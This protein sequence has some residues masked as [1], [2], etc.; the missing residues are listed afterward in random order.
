MSNQE[1]KPSFSPNQQTQ[2]TTYPNGTQ[3]LYMFNENKEL[4]TLNTAEQTYHYQRDA[5]GRITSINSVQGTQLNDTSYSYDALGRLIQATSTPST[6]SGTDVVTEQS[7]STVTEFTY[8]KAGNNLHKQSTYDTRMNQLLEDAQYRY[9]Y[10][11]NGN[12]NRKI[13]KKTNH[14]HFYRYNDLNQLIEHYKA[15][16]TDHYV[17]RLLY[18]YDGFNRRVTKTYIDSKDKTKSYAHHYLYDD[19]NI[20][21]IL[22]KNNNK[23]LLAT[24][25][26]HPTQIDTPLSITNH[27]T[28]KTYYYHRDHQGSIVALTNEEGKVVE[29]ITYDGHYGVILQHFKQETTL[30]P[31]GYTGRETDTK[32]LY[33]YRARYYDPTTQRFLSRDPIEFEAGDFNFYRYVGN[34][35]VNF[36]DPTGLA[37]IGYRPLE[38]MP[39]IIGRPGSPAD[40]D[41][42]LVA[43]QHIWFDSKVTYNKNDPST[44][45][46]V[47]F[48][49]NKLFMDASHT[50]SDYK[51]MKYYDD[52]ILRKAVKSV[53]NPGDYSLFIGDNNCQDYVEKVI[54]EYYR[55][56]GK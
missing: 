49:D 45:S 41:N 56:G 1:Q 54:Q 37:Q 22:D 36:R 19:Q 18:T 34:D 26:H 31:Y 50:R 27:T 2:T 7:R 8:D 25:V 16:E 17:Y 47:G 10:D 3:E 6:S 21:A 52:T 33:Y 9:T 44:W 23:Q 4:I 5:L 51:Y 13:D 40:K 32:D 20:I 46:N 30:N 55:L 38:G 15:D 35:C 29:H 14:M 28:N 53:G 12:L 48:T 24:I 11:A 43:H 42:N 39:F